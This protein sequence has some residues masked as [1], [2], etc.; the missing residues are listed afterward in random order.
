MVSR[1]RAWRLDHGLTLQELGDLTGLC[2][3]MVSRVERGERS[4]LP[5]TRIK[6]ARRLNVPVREIFDVERIPEDER[7]EAR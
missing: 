7:A 1:L 6:V 4:L 2:P 5:L 3:S